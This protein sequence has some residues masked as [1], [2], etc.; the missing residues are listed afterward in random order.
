PSACR[1]QSDDI[2]VGAYLSLSGPDATFGTDTREGLELAVQ[3]T[4]AAG[5]V[6]GRRVTMVYEDDK[7]TTQEAAQKVRQLIDGSKAVAI[8]GEAAASRT[9]AGGLIANTSHVPMI[10]PSATAVDVTKDREWVFRVCFTDDQQG[11]VA[12]RWVREGL[13]KKRVAIL[14]VGQDTY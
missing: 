12:A 5:G 7:S 14:Y 13:A 6:R 10:T 11:K 4:N 9:L 8:T 1:R 2:V 3:E